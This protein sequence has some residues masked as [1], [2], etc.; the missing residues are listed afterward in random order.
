MSTPPPNRRRAAIALCVI[1]GIATA[2]GVLA[3]AGPESTLGRVVLAV[4]A[5]LGGPFFH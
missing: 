3:F 1:V 4:L 2:V 5:F